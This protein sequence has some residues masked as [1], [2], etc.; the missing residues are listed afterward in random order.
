VLTPLCAALQ[1]AKVLFAAEDLE[2][3]LAELGRYHALDEQTRY[4][5]GRLVIHL[6][7]ERNDRSEGGDRIRGQRF[8]VRLQGARGGCQTTRRSVLHDRAA[9]LVDKRIRGEQRTFEIEEIVEGELLAAFLAETGN[10]LALPL[11]IKRR[12]LARVLAVTQC[13]GTLEREREAIGERLGPLAAEPVGDRRIVRRRPRKDLLR[14][15]PA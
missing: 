5:R 7:G 12:P 15:Q 2:R 13:R 11:H 3:S 6:D 10:P 8:P 14:Q 9:S 1:H 4:R